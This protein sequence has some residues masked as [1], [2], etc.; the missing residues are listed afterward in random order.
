MKYRRAKEIPHRPR[1]PAA[2]PPTMAPVETFAP[3]LETFPPAP[4]EEGLDV[5]EVIPGR[6][7]EVVENEGF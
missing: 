3:E 6:V 4:V 7:N 5:R 1:I 2:I